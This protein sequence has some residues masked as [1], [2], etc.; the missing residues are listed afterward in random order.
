ML[1]ERFYLAKQYHSSYISRRENENIHSKVFHVTGRLCMIAI[2]NQTTH[3]D[4][5]YMSQFDLFF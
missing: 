1:Q 3:S 4:D 2:G 5:D